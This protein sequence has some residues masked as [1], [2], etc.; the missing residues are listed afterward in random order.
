MRELAAAFAVLA[1]AY[2]GWLAYAV[3]CFRRVNSI[4]RHL[5]RKV[6]DDA[7]R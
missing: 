4:S 7:R 6:S 3:R 2:V 1:L 5:D